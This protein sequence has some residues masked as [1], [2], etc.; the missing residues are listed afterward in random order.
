VIDNLEAANIVILT[1][2]TDEG[3]EWSSVHMYIQCVVCGSFQ[4]KRNII[5]NREDKRLYG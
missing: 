3:R 4:E 1:P 5:K 2:G